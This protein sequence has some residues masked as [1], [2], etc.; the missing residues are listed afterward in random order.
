M[1]REKFVSSV[2][3]AILALLVVSGCKTTGPS[4][5]VDPS[6]N[7]IQLHSSGDTRSALPVGDDVSGFQRATN[8]L[9]K[10]VKKNPTDLRAQMDLA[11]AHIAAN[12]LD[13]AEVLAKGVLRQDLK[14]QEVR[15]ILAQIAIRRGQFDMAEIFL[16]AV[17]GTD[18][19]D[20]SVLNMLAM[21]EMRRSRPAYAMAIFKKALGLNP[22]DVAVRMNLGVLHLKYRQMNQ[23]AVHFERVLKVVPGHQDARLHLAIIKALRGE[24]EVA[25]ETFKD[26]LSAKENNSLALF[27]LAVVERQTGE[28]D[29]ALD[30]LKKYLKSAQGRAAQADDVF[31][32]IDSIQK[33]RASKGQDIT[34]D[35]M[36]SLAAGVDKSE[37]VANSRSPGKDSKSSEGSPQKVEPKEESGDD[38]IEALERDLQ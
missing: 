10:H 16:G 5:N 21:I 37:R 35:E 12:D 31:A 26:I 27:N 20:T 24:T 29:D 11:Y 34:D 2:N 23:A 3:A 18:S 22:G 36:Q 4:T 28:Y 6:R 8:S 1:Y 19:K 14:N 7:E 15:K 30:Y 32:L 25:R 33:Q 9:A 38:E 13:E 17:G